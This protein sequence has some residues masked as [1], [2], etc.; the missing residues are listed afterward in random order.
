MSKMDPKETEKLQKYWEVLKVTITHFTILSRARLVC[1]K[2]LIGM[3][4][5]NPYV[6]GRVIIY[7][8]SLSLPL[9]L[10]IMKEICIMLFKQ[11][12]IT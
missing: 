7:I 6:L 2:L 8:S 10:D 1:A 3:Q 5:K 9:S 4:K 11:G 12:N